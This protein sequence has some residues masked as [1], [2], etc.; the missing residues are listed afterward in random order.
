MGNTKV[1]CTA[2][3]SDDVPDHA[4]EKN[5]GWLTAEYSMLP[6]ATTERSQRNRIASG[7]RTKEISRLIGR[8]L[9]A[10]L[11]LSAFPEVGI[12]IDCDV[13]QADGGTRTAAINGAFIAMIQALRR[14]QKEGKLAKWPVRDYIAAVSVGLIDR[15]FYLDLDY[16]KDVRAEVDMNIVMTGSGDFV[17]VQ[18][19]AEHKPFSHTD[20]NKLLALAGQGVKKILAIQKKTGGR[21]HS[22]TASFEPFKVVLA[23]HNQ[24]KVKEIMA[25]FT[26]TPIEFVTLDAFPGAPEV[27]E[28][29][30]TLEANAQ[31][32]AYE[33]AK[34]TK[35]ISLADDSGLEVEF[36]D[37]APGVISARFAG[38]GCS[39]ADNNNKLLKLL[40]GVP[41]EHRKARFRCVMALA[42]P[43]GA[44]Q[45]VEGALDGYITDR[46]RGEEGFGY[47]PVF[48]VPEQGKTLAE[49]GPTL[50]NQ[51]SHRYKALQGMKP[52]IL[53][54]RSNILEHMQ[55][56]PKKGPPKIV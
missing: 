4:K 52:I 7:G 22:M 35:Q 14:W 11:D 50:K 48:L 24:N 15:Q 32:K 33:I 6:R 41:T 36:L 49:L 31:K 8:S 47:D 28:D 25:I 9:R 55:K 10:I 51:I 13:L 30:D 39:Y 1:L 34:F 3:L 5:H 23:T 20:L 2:T 37:K 44:T 16:E 21:G 18:G 56:E 17:E 40:K 45:T 26:D 38:T 54:L 19:N 27:V 29:R 46:P 53:K 12:V 42:V 43:R